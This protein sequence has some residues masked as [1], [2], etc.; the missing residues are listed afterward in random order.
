MVLLSPSVELELLR[1]RF[2]QE[3]TMSGQQHKTFISLLGAL[4]AA[5]F[6]ATFLLA[7]VDTNAF[8]NGLQ[9]EKPWTRQAQ[10]LD[11][12][13]SHKGLQ[14]PFIRGKSHSM[15]RLQDPYRQPGCTC[16]ICRGVPR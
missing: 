6:I 8:L 11:T 16:N 3:S 14:H 9:S 15:P 10:A 12:R 7:S 2:G 13:A 5:C 1:A 4:V